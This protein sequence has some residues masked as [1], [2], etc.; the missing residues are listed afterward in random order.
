MKNNMK[1]KRLE[2]LFFHMIQTASSRN[3]SVPDVTGETRQNN[4]NAGQ[5]GN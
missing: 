4:T 2:K 5:V 3:R 1:G